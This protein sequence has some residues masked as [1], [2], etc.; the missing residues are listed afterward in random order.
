[1]NVEAEFRVRISGFGENTFSRILIACSG[2]PDSMALLDV[3]D[4]WGKET[5][6]YLAVGHVNHG[7]RGRASQGDATF[8]QKEAARRKLPCGVLSVPVRDWAARRGRGLEEAARELRYKALARLALRFRCAGVATAHTLDDQTETIFM[9]LIRGAGPGGLAGMREASPWP[10][11][12]LGKPPTL[13]RPFLNVSKKDVLHYLSSNN[14]PSRH[15][16]SNAKPIFLR[17]RLRPVLQSWNSLRPGFFQRMA[18][19]A[20][21]LQDEEEY[22]RTRFSL[23]RKTRPI[24]LERTSFLRYHVAE[25]RRRLRHLYGLTR[26]ESVERVRRFASDRTHG[27][28]DIPE[29]HVGKVG[30]F[31]FFH[32]PHR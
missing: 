18:Q 30:R 8:V 6:R 11:P 23:R 9:H 4:R 31:L 29:G 10:I 21:I 7:L 32:R 22:W 28:L 26:F 20:R 24:R 12:V 25:Q 15:D 5:D 27:P 13:L 14:I 17:N 3:A 16:A 1:M 19:T 2:G